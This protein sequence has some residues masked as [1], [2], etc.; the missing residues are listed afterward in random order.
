MAHLAIGLISGGGGDIVNLIDKQLIGR[1]PYC[2]IL[3]IHLL[4]IILKIPTTSRNRTY[5]PC[6]LSGM[7]Q[8]R[9]LWDEV[10]VGPMVNFP[11]DQPIAE[12]LRG[13]G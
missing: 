6:V 12:S 1:L 9:D 3:T 4:N 11:N 7:L 8:N 13:L 2:A 5:C 10:P